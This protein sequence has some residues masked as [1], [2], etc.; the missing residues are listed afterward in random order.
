MS[1]IIVGGGKSDFRESWRR[2]KQTFSYKK[3][4]I[5]LRPQPGPLSSGTDTAHAHTSRWGGDGPSEDSRPTPSV[6]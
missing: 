5:F 2:Q 3:E 6:P 1:G 4:Y